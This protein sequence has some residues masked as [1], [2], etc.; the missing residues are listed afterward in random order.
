MIGCGPRAE[1]GKGRPPISV[2]A[3]APRA[4]EVQVSADGREWSPV[5]AE[6]QGNASFTSIYI[7]P[8]A[9][10]FIRITLTSSAAEGSPW[11]VRNLRLLR[12]P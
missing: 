10:R 8:T 7:P 12:A 5:L 6:G 2:G 11:V 1:L 9:A 4:Y 3:G